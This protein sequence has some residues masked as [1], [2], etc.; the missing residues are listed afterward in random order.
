[1]ARS[2]AFSAAALLPWR[3]LMRLG[4]LASETGTPIYAWALMSNHL[5]RGR[6]PA[7]RTKIVRGL[8]EN[9]GVGIAKIARQVGI[10][11]SGVSKIITRTLSI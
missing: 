2:I 5:S 1:M 6:L 7:V 11:T 9:Y 3:R 4:A 8:V 10:S